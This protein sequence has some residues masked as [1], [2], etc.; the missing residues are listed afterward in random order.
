MSGFP[1][2]PCDVPVMGAPRKSDISSSVVVVLDAPW[3]VWMRVRVFPFFALVEIEY[4][5][6]VFA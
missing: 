2:K 3:F 4:P 1:E 5:D 6:T